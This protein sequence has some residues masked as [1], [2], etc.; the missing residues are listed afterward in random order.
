MSTVYRL[1][2]PRH[3]KKAFDLFKLIRDKLNL[4]VWVVD[5]RSPILTC[6]YLFEFI[7]RINYR[8]NLVIFVNKMDLVKDFDYK[9][10][11]K[12]LS[13]FSKVRLPIIYGCYTNCKQLYDYLQ[14][15]ALRE[16][17]VNCLFVGLPNVGKSSV[18]NCLVGRS[19]SEVS[20]KPGTTRNVKWI[21]LSYNIRVLDSPG[22]VLPLE[23]TKEEAQELINLGIINKSFII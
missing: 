9:Q 22:I 23:I 7:E 17:F 4:I 21:N 3:V 20:S 14:R 1:S 15:I 13:D 18:I 11:R 5:A 12:Y 2:Y 16:L 19:K 8:K 6:R 10:F